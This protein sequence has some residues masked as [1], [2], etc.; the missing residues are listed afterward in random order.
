VRAWL[1]DGVEPYAIAVATR[2][3]DLA[4]QAK[5]RLKAAGMTAV[6]PTATGDGVPTRWATGRS[7]AQCTAGD[8]PV[9]VGPLG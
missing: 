2:V 3:N 7:A 9:F 8:R 1:D 4:D 5:R 6:S